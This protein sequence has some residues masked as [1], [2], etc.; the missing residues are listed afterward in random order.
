MSFRSALCVAP[1]RSGDAAGIAAAGRQVR[2][3]CRRWCAA[4]ARRGNAAE[5][6]QPA[7]RAKSVI[8]ARHCCARIVICAGKA[9]RRYRRPRSS[10]VVYMRFGMANQQYKVAGIG[11][12]L[13]A[14]AVVGQVS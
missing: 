6:A 5:R 3:A 10:R 7:S 12:V 9:V 2:K 4:F 14:K 1:V 11:R 13:C 8:R